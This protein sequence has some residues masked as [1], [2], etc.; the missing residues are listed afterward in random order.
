MNKFNYLRPMNLAVLR[1]ALDAKAKAFTRITTVSQAQRMR[2][3][4]VNLLEKTFEKE[5]RHLLLE[6]LYPSTNGSTLV[7]PVAHISSFLDWLGM[8]EVVFE[9]KGARTYVATKATEWA[10]QEG[11]AIIRQ[12]RL[13]KGQIELPEQEVDATSSLPQ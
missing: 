9:T 11:D 5:G 10:K 4:L 3:L 1:Y 7:L 12:A 6:A 13:D 8:P 2:G